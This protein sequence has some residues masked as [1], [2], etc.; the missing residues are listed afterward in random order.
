[1]GDLVPKTVTVYLGDE[2]N[3]FLLK[4]RLQADPQGPIEVLDIF[5]EP[6]TGP[7]AHPLLVY[8]DLLHIGDP[9]TLEQAK[10]IHDRYLA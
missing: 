10:M 6:S 1:M 4:N 9:R 5:W 8:A 2:K 3:A 7:T